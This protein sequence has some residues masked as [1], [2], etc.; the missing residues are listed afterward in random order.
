MRARILSAAAVVALVVAGAPAARAQQ[1]VHDPRALAQMIEEA[2][3]TLDQLKALQ[4]QVE[5]GQRL[6]DSLNDLSDVN[7]LAG[8]L[9]LPTVR[10]PLPD[11]RSLRAAA[12]GDLG[13][14]GDLADRADAIRRDT[15]LYTP[16]TGDLSPAGAY[17]RDSLERAGARTARD[18]AVGEAVAG[19]AD[20]RLEGLETLRSALDTAPNARAVMDLEARL[21]AEQALIQNEQVRLQ[22]L[23]LTQAAEAR[24]EEQR[25]RERAEAARTA[26]MSVYERAFQ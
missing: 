24:L 9:G 17:Y 18:L 25:A 10:N 5:Q 21:A 16:P 4:T 6:F 3:T 15:R 26:R 11:M 1:I 13:A 14:L 22:G 8:E 7:A 19:A 23:A 12:N 20:R 2:R